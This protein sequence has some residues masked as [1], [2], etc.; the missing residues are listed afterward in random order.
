MVIVRLNE[1]DPSIWND[2]VWHNDQGSIFQTTYYL[3]LFRKKNK[4]DYFGFAAIEGNDIKGIVGGIILYDYF[5][6]LSAFTKRAIIQGGPIC[7]DINICELLLK[8]VCHYLKRRVVYIQFR[9]LR[10]MNDYQDAFIKLGYQYEKHLDIIHD[11]TRPVEEII[12]G[13]T[14]DRRANIRKSMNKGTVFR[15]AFDNELDKCVDLV[16]Q[17]YSRIGLPCFNREYFD[18]AFITL[19]NEKIIKVFVVT[20][21]NHI[22]ASRFEL[23]YKKLIYDWYAGADEQF[24]KLYPNDLMPYN[25]I[26]WG[27]GNGYTMFDF[28]GA[29][30]P[31]I[32]Y[33][34]RDFKKTFGGDTVEYGRYNYVCNQFKMDVGKAGLAITK[35]IK[36]LVFSLKRSKR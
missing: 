28:G 12:G 35:G 22:I 34:V 23:C 33:G 10:S 14:K 20:N 21:N 17:T 19:S 13:V 5:P 7:Q 15:E 6:P 32:P 11:L 29:G 36:H 1:L 27:K 3:S 9:N 2:Y 24:K 30:N 8:T 25:I 16:T 31:D 26:I 18:N 4:S